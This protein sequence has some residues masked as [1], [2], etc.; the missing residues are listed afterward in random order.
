MRDTHFGGADHVLLKAKRSKYIAL[1]RLDY[2]G[3]SDALGGGGTWKQYAQ[4]M[5]FEKISEDL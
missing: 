2:N 5:K 1:E 4:T 3:I